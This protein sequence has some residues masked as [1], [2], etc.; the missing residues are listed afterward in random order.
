MVPDRG[1]LATGRCPSEFSR[2]DIVID[3]REEWKFE[4]DG[5]RLICSMAEDDQ[6]PHLS[7]VTSGVVI[8]DH[9][10]H[11]GVDGSVCQQSRPP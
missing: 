1:L 4:I 9:P 8:T 7:S 3:T 6:C 2:F 11:K 5:C 10:S